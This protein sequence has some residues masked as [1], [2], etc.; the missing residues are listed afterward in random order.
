MNKD[1]LNSVEPGL[2]VH[3][4]SDAITIS[5][6]SEDAVQIPSLHS[7]QGS[8][9]S[10]PSLDLFTEHE[11]EQDNATVNRA[12]NEEKV[13]LVSS[14]SESDRL[15]YDCERYTLYN[16]VLCVNEALPTRPRCFEGFED[17]GMIEKEYSYLRT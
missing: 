8:S 14:E 2:G 3:K 4:E 11:S 10:L 12:Q 1:K 6:K 7:D 9:S 5:S 17:S 13:I 15:S 16:C